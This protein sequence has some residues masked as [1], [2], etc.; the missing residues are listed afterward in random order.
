MGITGVVGRYTT[1][2]GGEANRIHN[3]QLVAR[4]IDNKL[5]APGATFSFNGTTGARTAAKGFLEAPV[6]INGELSTGLGGGVCQVSTTVFNAAYE[7]GLKITARTNHALYISHYPQGRDATVNYPDI[8]LQV[9]Q[10]HRPLAAAADVRR[11]VLA[12]GRPLRRRRS[13]GASRARPRRS[14]SPAPPPVKQTPDPT[15]PKGETVIDDAR[16]RRRSSTTSRRKV[17]TRGGQAALRQHLVLVATAASRS[18]CASGRSR[19]R[20][21][22]RRKTGPTTTDRRR[23]RARRRTAPRPRPRRR[24]HRLRRSDL[25]GEPGRHARRAQ[26][27]ARRRR[28]GAS[29]RRRRSLVRRARPSTRSGSARRAARRSGR[30]SASRSS[31]RAGA[32]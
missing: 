25:V 16:R 32:R 12:R 20:S 8:D 6:I 27:G 23:P 18:S 31:K 3:V 26:R 19:S 17:Y 13:T 24:R 21:R 22:R 5:I 4:L 28:R 29:S 9:R 2:Y 1:I 10:R 30:G 15:L 11:L 14:S 7:A